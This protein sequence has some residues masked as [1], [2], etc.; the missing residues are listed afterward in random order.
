MSVSLSPRFIHLTLDKRRLEPQLYICGTDERS[1]EGWRL[2][3]SA[4]RARQI[5]CSTEDSALLMLGAPS[6]VTGA[7]G[8]CAEML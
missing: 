1:P 5:P 8:M 3:S 4:L 7:R 2:S 6:G